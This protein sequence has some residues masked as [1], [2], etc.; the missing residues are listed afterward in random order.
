MHYI[1]LHGFASS[2]RSTKARDLSDRF[3]A[4]DMSLSIPDLNQN[5]FSHLTLSRQ[6]QQVEALFPPAP[7]PV[8]LI[9]SSFGGLT[10]AWLGER[11]LQVD[12]LVLLAPAFSFLAHW[13]PRLGDQVEQ[14]QTDGYLSVYHYSEAK[15]LPLH[16]AF[17]TDAAQYQ[18]ESITR[19][20]STLILHGR[21]DDVIPLQASLDFAR[22]RPWIKLVE[23]DSSHAL[24]DVSTEIWQAIQSFCA[25]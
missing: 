19:S 4:L 24:T 7:A 3:A 23:L 6:I 1:Y 10:A 20:L 2:P 17:V 12:R 15:E 9:G 8:T 16:Y 13:L 21:H 18:E 11:H 14:W 22:T 25:L 5:D